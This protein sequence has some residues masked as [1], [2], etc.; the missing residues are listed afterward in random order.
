MFKKYTTIIIL[1]LCILTCFSEYKIMA[2]K[3]EEK[4]GIK[5]NGFT[6]MMANND[7]KSVYSYSIK[8]TN[9]N[10]RTIFIKSIQPSINKAI[11][12]NILSK[13]I[14]V[15]V[16]KSIKPDESIQVDGEILINGRGL[17]AKNIGELIDEIKVSTEESLS[18]R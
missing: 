9:T 13:Q 16:N 1:I 4:V 12:S 18:I 6:Y 5:S 17:N 2:S 10:V 14:I 8:L 11:R 15:N 7:A 3:V